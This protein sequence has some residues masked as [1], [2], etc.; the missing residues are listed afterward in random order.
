MISA[1]STTVALMAA[2]MWISVPARAQQAQVPEIDLEQGRAPERLNLHV[3]ARCRATELM[4]S[5]KYQGARLSIGAIR[6]GKQ[7]ASRQQLEAANA[8]MPADDFWTFRYA[9]CTPDGFV[10]FLECMGGGAQDR[11]NQARWLRFKGVSFT[12]AGF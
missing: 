10:L 6:F 3:R 7:A 8:A 9:E 5:L 4:V 2:A 11:G 12:E 1:R